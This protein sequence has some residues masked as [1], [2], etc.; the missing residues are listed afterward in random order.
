ML[1]ISIS[2][3]V[4]VFTPTVGVERP[5]YHLNVGLLKDFRRMPYSL[6]EVRI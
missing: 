1:Q 5:S 3:G 4:R 2:V 6:E